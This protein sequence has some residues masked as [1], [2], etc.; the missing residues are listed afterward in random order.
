MRAQAWGVLFPFSGEQ[1]WGWA[2][3][4]GQAP[5]WLNPAFPPRVRTHTCARP[6]TS[7]GVRAHTAEA[8]T[9]AGARVFACT[10][11]AWAQMC[12]CK[13]C[14]APVCTHMET[15]LSVITGC[16]TSTCSQ[17]PTRHPG[18]AA[19]SLIQSLFSF[20]FFFLSCCCKI[21]SR[22]SI[23]QVK[24]D[25]DSKPA[26]NHGV[27]PLG[28]HLGAPG[29][30][31][32]TAPR[33]R[34]AWCVCALLISPLSQLFSPHELCSAPPARQ[35]AA[36]A[37]P[38]GGTA[39]DLPGCRHPVPQGHTHH[40]GFVHPVHPLPELPLNKTIPAPRGEIS[41]PKVEGLFPRRIRLC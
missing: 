39:W 32:G 37:L 19:H 4:S 11:G 16:T 28:W 15:P 31:L 20:F 29:T 41:S 1:S 36:V 3:C 21:H 35:H 13:R 2:R 10:E 33:A 27:K 8:S 30:G 22:F 9:C 23:V 14:W 24:P 26:T 17:V 34:A 12:V 18:Q 6:R 25:M 38:E 5:K 7:T 40:D